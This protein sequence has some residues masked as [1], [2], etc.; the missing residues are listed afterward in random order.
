M[1]Q[2]QLMQQLEESRENFLEL[3][4]DLPDEALLQTGVCGNWSIRDVLYHLARWE[5]ELISL[6]WQTRQGGTPSTVHFGK[7]TDAQIN[8]QWEK[9]GAERSLARI[10]DDFHSVRAQT[11]R[12]IE[13]FS[14]R[15]LT[16]PQRY[17]WLNN[18][19]LYQWI[20]ESTVEHET[21]HGEQIRA[22]KATQ[23]ASA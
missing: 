1:T 7:L 19:P 15:D 22:W 17:A 20:L 18:R 16:N 23:R 2:D 3:L 14:E 13:A 12:R 9:E 8:A 6:L 10:L 11:L 4:E 21:E 5:A